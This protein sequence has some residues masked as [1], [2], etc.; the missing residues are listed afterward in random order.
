MAKK[1]TE[2]EETIRTSIIL[3]RSLHDRLGYASVEDRI[4]GTEIVRLALADWLD[5]RDRK[6]KGGTR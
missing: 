1:K 2:P 4:S 5:R 3:P 6:R